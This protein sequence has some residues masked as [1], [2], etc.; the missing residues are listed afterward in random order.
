MFPT[1]VEKGLHP[2]A[3]KDGPLV[4]FLGMYYVRLVPVLDKAIQKQQQIELLKQEIE[5]LKN[6]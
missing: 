3:K 6:K 4:E 1:L 5:L 2:D